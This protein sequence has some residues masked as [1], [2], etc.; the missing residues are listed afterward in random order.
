MSSSNAMHY[1]VSRFHFCAEVLREIEALVV[2]PPPRKETGRVKALIITA[3]L[4]NRTVV[5]STVSH[6]PNRHNQ[7]T[8]HGA[9]T[10]TSAL[11][12]RRIIRCTAHLPQ[13]CTALKSPDERLV[14]S[15]TRPVFS[16]EHLD[17]GLR[18]LVML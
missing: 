8:V 18:R 17:E 1:E 3:L 9:P 13:G 2:Y 16:R 6:P 4:I 12:R 14:P 11:R 7:R 10:F 15:R 5:P